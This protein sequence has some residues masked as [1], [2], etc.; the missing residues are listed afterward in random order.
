MISEICIEGLQGSNCLLFWKQVYN[1]INGLKHAATVFSAGCKV[2]LI[3]TDS[4]DFKDIFSDTIEQK[5]KI[6]FEPLELYRP[7][8]VANMKK[9]EE[10]QS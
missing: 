8:T 9:V 2:F 6:C 5:K 7:E 4:F 10:L 1:L 3:Y